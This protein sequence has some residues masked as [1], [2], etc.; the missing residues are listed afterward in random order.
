MPGAPAGVRPSH[1]PEFAKKVATVSA[2]LSK[3]FVSDSINRARTDYLRDGACCLRS[4]VGPR[5]LEVVRRGL[6]ASMAAPTP[7]ARIWEA[8]GGAGRFFQDVFAWRGIADLRAFALHSGIAEHVACILQSEELRLYS[9]HVLIREGMS[10]ETPWHQDASYCFV[11]GTQFCSVWMPVVPVSRQESLQLVRGSH[12]WGDLYLPVE[13]ASKASYSH[14][15]GIAKEVPRITAGSSEILAWDLDPGDC[16]IFSALT[17]H[18]APASPPIGERR[19]VYVTRWIGDD[20]TYAE[21]TWSVPRMPLAPNLQ[22]GQQFQGKLFPL[23]LRN[24][25]DDA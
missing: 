4:V 21:P 23:A 9:D 11:R 14:E 3:P 15:R 22:V 5:W 8:P 6:N 10:K 18:S 2:R 7:L 24:G 19:S 17:L 20:A 25:L 12:A 1:E 13:F 16:I